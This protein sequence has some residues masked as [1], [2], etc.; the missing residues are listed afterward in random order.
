M[1]KFVADFERPIHELEKHLN[2]LKKN[3]S[4]T[5][6][7]YAREIF[8]LEKEIDRLKVR[9][10]RNLTPWQRVQLAR[11]PERPQFL[12]YLNELF[13][14][15][16]ELRG[17]RLYGDDRAIIAGLAYFKNFKVMVVG[18]E[19]GG[20]TKSK[21]EHNF[22]MPHPRGYRKA[23]RLFRLA[24]KFNLPVV[25]FIDTPGAYPGI[26]SEEH[27]QAGAIARNLEILAGLRVPV[28]AINIGEGGSGGAL[29]LGVADRVFMMENA[30]YSVITP[31]GCA[32]IL[33]G[34]SA[35]A[36]EA[37]GALALTAEKLLK[38]KLIDGIIKEPLG[39][40]RGEVLSVADEL[41]EIVL[42]ALE[43]LSELNGD[44]LVEER[45]RRLRKIGVFSEDKFFELAQG[46]RLI[47]GE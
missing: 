45:Y 7:S 19:K 26:E 15:F 25:N 24:A 23:A 29:A 1:A 46:M 38:F 42:A 12:D 14:G 27:G 8:R 10:Y 35:R 6:T 16:I 3:P 41:R 20:D 11:H 5:K 47:K 34:D 4:S 13:E 33:W 22:G 44:K 40:L 9:V 17:D 37:A 2:S 30:Y 28:I 32:S 31:E 43:E 36:A 21:L 39:G 18:N